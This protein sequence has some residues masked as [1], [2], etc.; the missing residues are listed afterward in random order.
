MQT[1]TTKQELI[2]LIHAH[3]DMAPKSTWEKVLEL[4]EDEEDLRDYDEA[5]EN[6]KINRTVPEEEIK[7]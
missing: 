5:Q 6:I 2:K 3:L 7:K 1:T 4:L